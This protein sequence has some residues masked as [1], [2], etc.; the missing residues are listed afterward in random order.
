[1][2]Y[3]KKFL[4]GVVLFTIFLVG[5]DNSPMVNSPMV[6]GIAVDDEASK[7]WFYTHFG[8]HRYIVSPGY[9]HGYQ[10]GITHD[11][12]CSCYVERGR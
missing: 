9:S 2:K 12:D 1:M 3:H 6:N 11:P 4:L 10:S 8:K 7:K 5:C